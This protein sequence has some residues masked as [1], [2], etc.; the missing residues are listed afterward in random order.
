MI[1]L[2]ELP[3]HF[4]DNITVYMT[5]FLTLLSYDHPKLRSNVL[6]FRLKISF[7]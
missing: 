3:E 4:E 1:F 7:I 6:F 2:K 5:H